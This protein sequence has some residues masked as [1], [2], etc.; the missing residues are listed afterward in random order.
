MMSYP[1]APRHMTSLVTVTDES[2]KQDGKSKT[3]TFS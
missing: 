1:A 2:M 3:K